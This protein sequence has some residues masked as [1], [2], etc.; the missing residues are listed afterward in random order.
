M[1]FCYSVTG[2]TAFLIKRPKLRKYIINRKC[3]NTRNSRNC[4]NK[5]VKL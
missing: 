4:R 3:R 5:L 1:I 2:V